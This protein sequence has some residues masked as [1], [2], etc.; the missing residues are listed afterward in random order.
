MAAIIAK[1]ALQGHGR[2]LTPLN[3]KDSIGTLAAIGRER[4]NVSIELSAESLE[5]IF[6]RRTLE[7]RSEKKIV[8]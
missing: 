4:K 3:E 2:A 8:S 7:N 5:S 1:H 6:E